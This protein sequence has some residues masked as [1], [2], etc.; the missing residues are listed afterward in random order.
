MMARMLIDGALMPTVV[1]HLAKMRNPSPTKVSDQDDYIA[2]RRGDQP[3]AH[4]QLVD[5]VLSVRVQVPTYFNL[6]SFKI[7]NGFNGYLGIKRI[8]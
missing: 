2:G 6:I 5:R 7:I 1:P 3:S 4:R 8:N